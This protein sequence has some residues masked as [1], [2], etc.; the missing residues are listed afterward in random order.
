MQSFSAHISFY[1]AWTDKYH[2][3]NKQTAVAEYCDAA[4]PRD[5]ALLCGSVATPTS[6]HVGVAYTDA[7]WSSQWVQAPQPL[8]HP[9]LQPFR[10][11]NIVDRDDLCKYCGQASLNSIQTNQF[12]SVICFSSSLPQVQCYRSLKPTTKLSLAL[13]ET[14]SSDLRGRPIN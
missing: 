12:A 1:L 3:Q 6:P 9:S 8:G 11:R 4:W 13:A 7:M 5:Q 14:T 2:T 10:L